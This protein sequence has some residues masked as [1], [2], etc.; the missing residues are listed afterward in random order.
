MAH[1]FLGKKIEK[2]MWKQSETETGSLSNVK[3]EQE[4]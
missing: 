3:T 1:L 4:I 2:Q